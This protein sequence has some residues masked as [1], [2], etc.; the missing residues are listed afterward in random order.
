MS[1]N[2][3]AE[4]PYRWR[5][6]GTKMQWSLPEVGQIVAMRHVAWRVIEVK[7]VPAEDWTDDERER[8]SGVG[9][10][11]DAIVR[12]FANRGAHPHHVVVRPATIKGS[13]VRDRDRDVHLRA[14]D[15]MRWDAYPN[16]RYPVC[17]ECG[18]PVPCRDEMAERETALAAKDADAHSVPGVCPA[19][20]EPVTTRH[21]KVITFEVNLK[22]PLGGPVTFHLGKPGCRGDARDYEELLASADPSYVR[23]LSCGGTATS[24][25]E[26]VECSEGSLCRGLKLPHKAVSYCGGTCGPC[27]AYKDGEEDRI[28]ARNAAGDWTTW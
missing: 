3:P 2:W 18:Q 14:C 24:H 13:D 11:A 22:V 10:E 17:A 27:I 26:T 16:H 4:P 20:S 28:K 5:P 23:V 7:P 25:Y 12:R 9:P 8:V 21:R 1:R 15:G 6:E 19:C